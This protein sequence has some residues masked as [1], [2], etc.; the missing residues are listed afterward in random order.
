[1]AD[2]SV[3]AQA[4]TN[5]TLQHTREIAAPQLAAHQDAIYLNPKLFARVQAFTAI[6]IGSISIRNHASWSR[7]ITT[8]SCT[9]APS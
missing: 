3:M 2:F 7:C 9:P 8:A 5:P 1:M 6:S 4:D